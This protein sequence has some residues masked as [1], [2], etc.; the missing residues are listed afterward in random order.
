MLSQ[1]E[2]KC[3]NL[4]GHTYH[5]TITLGCPVG[6]TTGMVLDYND[7]KKHV[8]KLDHA[9]IFSA[10]EFRSEAENELLAWALKHNMR[11]VQLD[12]G[13]STAENIVKYLMGCFLGFN[14]VKVSLSETDG[15]W[16][17]EE[18]II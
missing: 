5:G 11:L 8:D 16:A 3:A 6:A 12:E 9:I 18:R 15:S 4:H 1:Y 10:P 2:G 7:I 13:K 14:Y 17:E